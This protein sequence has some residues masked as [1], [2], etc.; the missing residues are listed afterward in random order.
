MVGK[1][2]FPNF[3]LFLFSRPNSII[4]LWLTCTGLQNNK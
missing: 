2:M 4:L 1:K 3:S